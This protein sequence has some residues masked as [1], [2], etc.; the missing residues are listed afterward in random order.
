MKFRLIPLLTD[1]NG[2]FAS[3]LVSANLSTILRHYL[4]GRVGYCAHYLARALLRYFLRYYLCAALR[5]RRGLAGLA[6]RPMGS[7]GTPSSLSFGSSVSFLFQ[8][9]CFRMSPALERE[10][11]EGLAESLCVHALSPHRGGVEHRGIAQHAQIT[12]YAVGRVVE[13][14]V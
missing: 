13:R 3:A 1:E 11:G 9:R 5:L 14:L 7:R 6:S 2:Y 10:I 4:R 8:L 12:R